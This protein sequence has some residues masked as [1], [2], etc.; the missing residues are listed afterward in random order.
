M[1]VGETVIVTVAVAGAA[2]QSELPVTVYVVVTKGL[3]TGLAM[4]VEFRYVAGVHV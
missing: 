2:P 4:V 1:M 3:A